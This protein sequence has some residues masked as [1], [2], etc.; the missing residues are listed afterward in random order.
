MQACEL[1]PVTSKRD[2]PFPRG[3]ISHVISVA[4]LKRRRLIQTGPG[5]GAPNILASDFSGSGPTFGA[6][7]RR[8][9][10]HQRPVDLPS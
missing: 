5:P 10:G 4:W 1:R 3:C 9:H 6:Q 2:P 7:S 8:D